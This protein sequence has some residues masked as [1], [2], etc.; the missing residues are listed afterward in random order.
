MIYSIRMDLLFK[1]TRD[2]NLHMGTI[3]I[4]IYKLHKFC[5]ISSRKTSSRKVTEF[6]FLI[7]KYFIFKKSFFF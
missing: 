6:F 4:H 2:K 5:H 3:N 1:I 7:G